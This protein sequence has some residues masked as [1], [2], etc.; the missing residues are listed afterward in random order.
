M[1]FFSSPNPQKT[2]S[3]M[4]PDHAFFHPSPVPGPS[5][6]HQDDWAVPATTSEQ[7]FGA[8]QGIT[9][10]TEEP[11]GLGLL[12]EPVTTD[13]SYYYATTVPQSQPQTM[14]FSWPTEFSASQPSNVHAGPVRKDSHS[15]A[16]SCDPRSTLLP[17]SIW[18]PTP[19]VTAYDTSPGRSEY[20]TSSRPSAMSSPYAHSEGFV[21]TAGSPFVKVEEPQ[22]HTVPRISFLHGPKLFEQSMLINPGD[23][24]TQ[25][26][27]EDRITAAF[28]HPSDS[29]SEAGDFTTPI[30]RPDH[31][32]AWSSDHFRVDTLEERPKRAYTQP[33][34]ASCSC[35]Q[36]GKLFQRSY[37]LK[38]HMETHDPHRSQP[39]ICRYPDCDK[40]FVRKT[41][42]IRHEGCV[43]RSIRS[44]VSIGADNTQVHLKN[45]NFTCKRCN[46]SFARK[47]TLRRYAG[48]Q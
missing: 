29:Q 35:T 16:E 47:D 39:H 30:F 33:E 5:H 38:A 44:P 6:E 40:R 43:S 20:S 19:S 25:P 2:R 41:D 26:P 48:F 37:N 18:E 27:I 24:V 32:R 42:L 13:H 14:A 28:L 1:S 10:T 21:R 23:L 45:R 3:A 22:E 11:R 4:T 17:A 15:W 36:C 46:S 12:T 9:W 34:N 31:R 8:L 7:D